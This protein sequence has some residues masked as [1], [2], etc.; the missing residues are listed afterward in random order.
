[1]GPNSRPPPSSHRSFSCF[2]SEC[3]DTSQNI[4][5]GI[6]YTSNASVVTSCRCFWTFARASQTAPAM[7][8]A[9]HDRR[10]TTHAYQTVETLVICMR[11]L[12]DP[13]RLSIPISHNE[14]LIGI[15]NAYPDGFAL[16]ALNSVANP[17]P[18]QTDEHTRCQVPAT[19]KA[20]QC[21][22]LATRSAGAIRL[23]SV[24]WRMSATIP[25]S[26]PLKTCVSHETM[27][28]V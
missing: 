28:M 7:R 23:A 1:M 9:A 21:Q 26:A 27:N 11:S 24:A 15:L 6:F 16:K 25:A 12:S 2:R 4:L 22:V 8:A 5:Y 19:T 13:G 20:S 10:Q 14:I 3:T 18:A 17:D